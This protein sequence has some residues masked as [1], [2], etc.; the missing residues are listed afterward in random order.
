MDTFYY[1]LIF[2]LIVG[3]VWITL[4]T[5]IAERFGS[6]VGGVIGGLPSTAVVAFFF[7]AWTQ[8]P[9]QMFDVTTVFPMTFAANAIYLVVY[10]IL[11]R[12]GLWPG[13][14]GGLLVW[15]LL[16][17]LLILSGVKSFPASL[18]IWLVI[19]LLSYHILENRLHVRSHGRVAIRYSPTQVAWRGVFAGA[20]VAFAVVMSKVGGPIVGSIFSSFP[21]LFT[22]TMII[23]A[24]SAGVQFARALVTPLLISSEVNVVVFAIALRYVILGVS[25]PAAIAIAYGVS[26]VSAYLT[27]L[28]IKAKLT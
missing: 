9:Q 19:L 17:T 7:I 6:K 2:S 10:A 26:M 14:A 8:G 5:I 22:S 24:R 27:Y 11:V 3:G 15:G 18:V 25:L 21:A 4:A 1:K 16:E 28:F 20:M 12:R 13:I 23:T